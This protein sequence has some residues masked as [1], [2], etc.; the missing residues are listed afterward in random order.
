MRACPD[1]CGATRDIDTGLA[2]DAEVVAYFATGDSRYRETAG[3]IA[4]CLL[5]GRNVVTT[6]LVVSS[7]SPRPTSTSMAR[8]RN[9]S[10]QC[11]GAFTCAAALLGMPFGDNAD[12]PP[13]RRALLEAIAKSIRKMAEA[14]SFARD[15]TR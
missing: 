11:G 4:R 14:S 2:I 3:D 9:T 13:P 15:L 8:A 1:R 6:S 5:A 7:T 12:S 10:T